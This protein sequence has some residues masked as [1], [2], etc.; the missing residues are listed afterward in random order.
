[1]KTFDW[2][3]SAPQSTPLGDH[4]VPVTSAHLR[5]KRIALLVCGGIA[6]MKTPLLARALRRRGADV[7][8]FCSDES[9]RY[10]GREALE[11]STCHDLVTQLT[12]RA[13]HLSDAQ[14]FDCYLVAPATY[15]TIGKVAAGIADTVVTAALASALGRLAQGR[16]AVVV[17]PTMHGSMHHDVLVDNCRA[18]AARG[19]R[20]VTPRDDYGKHNLPDEELLVAAVCR[21]VSRSSLRG[22]R[23]LVTGGPTP[24]PIDGVRRIVNRFRGRLG[25]AIHEELLL[26]GAD[27]TFVLGDGAW[28]PAHWMP[29][30]VV[31]TYDEYKE[32]VLEHVERGQMA[33]IFSAG[34][35]DYRPEASVVGK[36]PDGQ[37]R[38]AL[39]LVPTEKVIDL[40]R[41][42]DPGMFVVS[43]T[44]REGVTHDA[45][46]AEARRRLDRFPVVVANRGEETQGTEQVAWIVTANGVQ[47]VEGKATIASAIVD[48]LEHRPPPG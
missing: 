44:Y 34:V 22:Q 23:V 45:L 26:R 48:V 15:N 9:L 42:R 13:E 27:S 2:D 19:V 31:R 18:L 37:P 28:R 29:V 43:F 46:L 17:A 32:R 1:M 4:D 35:V 25:A 8:A 12:W 14:P 39:Q 11:W 6:A 47:R 10:V 40:A 38:W 21:A 3:F 30:D 41:A 20:F 7:V 24:V 33:G 5:G 36:I 16:T